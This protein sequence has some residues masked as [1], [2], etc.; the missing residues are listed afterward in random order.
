MPGF[1]WAAPWSAGRSRSFLWDGLVPLTKDKLFRVGDSSK[2][3][4]TYLTQS[5]HMST[6]CLFLYWEFKISFQV[7]G[8]FRN[9]Q[10][11]YL[12]WR[13]S[14]AAVLMPASCKEPW[15][16][17]PDTVFRAIFSNGYI[18]DISTEQDISS[19]SGTLLTH[20][21]LLGTCLHLEYHW[22]AGNNITVV[23]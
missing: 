10:R 16:S 9:V 13:N 2:V 4:G 8:R 12:V 19:K 14:A 17:E 5:T 11:G 20:N 1:G 7:S 18:S 15:H 21:G 3:D 6:Q 23:Q 22:S